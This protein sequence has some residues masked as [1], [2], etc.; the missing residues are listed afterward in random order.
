MKYMYI[1]RI[2]L[3]LISSALFASADLER[4]KKEASAR[5]QQLRKKL[6][7][8]RHNAGTRKLPGYDSYE[9]PEV[10]LAQQFEAA[11]VELRAL[12]VPQGES[13]NVAPGACT[14]VTAGAG[15]AQAAAAASATE[16]D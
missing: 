4:R 13:N 8:A 9:G 11:I 15:A 7:E 14:V 1:A 2:S 5:V 6:I 10:L 3:S 12:G 16:M